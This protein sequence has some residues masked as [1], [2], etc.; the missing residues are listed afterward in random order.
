V[1]PTEGPAAADRGPDI[2]EGAQTL[3]DFVPVLGEDH[4]DALPT[5]RLMHRHDLAGRAVR[6]EA[7]PTGT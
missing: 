2:D 4:P 3:A 5:H 6:S 1:V 7:R